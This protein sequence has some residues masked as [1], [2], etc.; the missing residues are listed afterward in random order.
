[1]IFAFSIGVA[2]L[3]GALF[4]SDFFEDWGDFRNGMFSP[5]AEQESFISLNDPESAQ[6]DGFD[7]LKFMLY[8]VLVVGSGCLTYAL[9][10]SYFGQLS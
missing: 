8:L 10:Q 5:T 9:L 1:M 2:F 7:R 4:F 3:T 6:E